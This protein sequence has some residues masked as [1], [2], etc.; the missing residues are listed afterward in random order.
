MMPD[1]VVQRY[2]FT[3]MVAL[4]VMDI[5]WVARFP[6]VGIM[7]SVGALY[8]QGLLVQ[9][10]CQGTAPNT[11]FHYVILVWTIGNIS[12]MCSEYMWEDQEPAG[13]LKII[14]SV[15]D[16]GKSLWFPRMLWFSSMVLIVNSLA[17]SI[18]YASQ[19]ASQQRRQVRREF[20]GERSVFSVPSIMY[21]D[22]YVFPWLLSDSCW[23]LA[24]H[25]ALLGEPSRLL[26]L[27]GILLGF[28]ALAIC[29]G[30]IQ[31]QA[32]SLQWSE[33]S[34]RAA[35]FLWVLGNVL[36]FLADALDV[37]NASTRCV[38]IV[39]FVVGLLLFVAGGLGIQKD[40]ED[41]LLF[42]GEHSRLVQS[43]DGSSMPPSV[44][45]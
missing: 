37:D 26:S 12:W 44:P 10:A 43:S 28:C 27:C 5:A 8:L 14:P 11:I 36:W 13:M 45:L 40:Q 1:N 31:R 18:F 35:E 38:V 2:E 42:G 16:A 7:A 21:H 6:L 3:V 4:F 41:D 39:T 9:G 23:V 30:E 25:S 34:H 33:V 20:R 15:F 32:P 29:G 24:N 19:L 17:L 22:L